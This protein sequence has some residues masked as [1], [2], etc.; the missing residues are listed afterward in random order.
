MSS[1]ILIC[2]ILLLNR[3][4]SPGLD[5]KKPDATPPKPA[6]Q[7]SFERQ[8]I[9]E[10]D[11]VN[12]ELLVS[13]DSDSALTNTSLEVAAPSFFEW[14]ATVCDDKK[15]DPPLAFG[16]TPLPLGAINARSL[17]RCH[18]QVKTKPTI[19]VG[20]FDSLFIVLYQWK[21]DKNTGTS[22]VTTEK[23]LKVNL[24]G[25]ESVAGIPLA[26]AGFIVPG[27]IFWL[28][29]KLF[30]VPWGM[31]GLGD[32]MIYSV[33]VSVALVVA[34]TWL[35]YI[36][37][38]MG[39]SIQ[40]LLRLALAG[41]V[42]GVFVGG[43]DLALRWIRARRLLS[44]QINEGDDELTLLG[45][46]LELRTHATLAQPMLEIKD[47]L[48]YVGSLGAR[49]EMVIKGQAEKVVLYS[50]VGSF[51]MTEPAPGKSYSDEFQ[52]LRKIGKM[53]ELIKLAN[54]NKLIDQTDGI[55]T[56]DNSG[57]FAPTGSWHKQWR[58]S[59][60][61]TFATNVEGW[62]TPTIRFKQ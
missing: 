3:P 48:K 11:L 54:K 16:A 5:D 14:Y 27:L 25:S 40:K 31:E 6:V 60:V 21:T 45:K 28:V 17:A 30:N 23:A 20:E 47:D 10:N 1:V 9:R 62:S 52:R 39:V 37:V 36:D 42:A 2:L 51:E 56:V 50:L 46:L 49:T 35:K 29:V 7:V 26:L 8:N 59:Q 32:R 15:F 55:Q 44:N 4:P 58:E 38:S 41:L 19:E 53:R 43:G 33:L 18:L 61:K 34:G 12:F 57:A 22:F 24:L 13:N